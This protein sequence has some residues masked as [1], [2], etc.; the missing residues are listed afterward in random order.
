MLL[1]NSQLDKMDIYLSTLGNE[2]V[3]AIGWG[4]GQWELARNN[5]FLL[6]DDIRVDNKR[7]THPQMSHVHNILLSCTS[8]TILGF[9]FGIGW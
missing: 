1:S 5:I 4:D 6:L 8:V 3:Y 9:T 7:L 2:Y